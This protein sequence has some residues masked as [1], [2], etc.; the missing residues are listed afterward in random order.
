MGADP[1]RLSVPSFG[2]RFCDEVKG[3]QVSPTDL[4]RH[5]GRHV[6]KRFERLMRESGRHPTYLD[7]EGDVFWPAGMNDED[8][9][10][11]G[12][13]GCCKGGY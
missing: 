8:S 11:R 3:R 9:S 6:L 12:A 10:C 7:E 4:A 1:S 5:K 13:R 2:S